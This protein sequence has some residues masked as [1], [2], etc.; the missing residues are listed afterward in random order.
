[1]AFDEG[2][3]APGFFDAPD[4]LLGVLYVVS[5]I[6]T[7]LTLG[8]AHRPRPRQSRRS[9]LQATIHGVREAAE[10]AG[11]DRRPYCNHALATLATTF[12][13]LFYIGIRAF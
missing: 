7:P 5:V 9:D 10:R 6:T 8:L 11:R 13:S 3:F 1:M 4:R 12:F 2:R